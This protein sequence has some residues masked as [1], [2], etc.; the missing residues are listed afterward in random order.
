MSKD[1]GDEVNQQ[2]G[3]GGR[4]I[5]LNF[6]SYNQSQGGMYECRVNGPGNNTERL[7][8]CIGECYT[9]LLTVKP[10]TYDSGVFLVP[11]IYHLY[12]VHI[13]QISTRCS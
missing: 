1:G 10:A 6:H 2:A 5:H 3:G 11:S 7:A 8:V 12:Y 13:I 9:V 4:I